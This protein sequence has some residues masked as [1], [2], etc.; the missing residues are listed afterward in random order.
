MPDLPPA[1]LYCQDDVIYSLRL[2]EYDESR[3]GWLPLQADDV[4]LEFVMLD[5]YVRTF[6]SHD[7]QGRYFVKFTIPDVYGV[8]KFRVMYR[9]PG[10]STVMVNTPVRRTP[11]YTL[12][13]SILYNLVANCGPK[14]FALPPRRP[15]HI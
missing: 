8:Y 10:Y 2:E 4:Q 14:L 9:R 13:M 6:L 15:A 12:V 7:K 3:G 1:C 11:P 5:P